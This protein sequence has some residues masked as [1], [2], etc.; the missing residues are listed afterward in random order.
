MDILLRKEN[1]VHARIQHG[2]ITAHGIKQLLLLIGRKVEQGFLLG[3]DDPIDRLFGK[4]QTARGQAD[5]LPCRPPS[6]ESASKPSRSSFLSDELTV[7]RG[8]ESATQISL[9]VMGA[10]SVRR[11]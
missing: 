10:S 6:P 11:M 4:L 9:C 8:W 2:V 7:C 1:V 3:L 5:G